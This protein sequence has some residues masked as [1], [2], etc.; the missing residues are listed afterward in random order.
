MNDLSFSSIV[1][2]Y[3]EI[4]RADQTHCQCYYYLTVVRDK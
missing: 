3:V 1:L 4:T 2:E